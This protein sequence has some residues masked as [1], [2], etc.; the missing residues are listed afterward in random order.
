MSSQYTDV[1][2]EALSAR[3]LPPAGADA[4]R[5]VDFDITNWFLR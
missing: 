3:L 5:G 1:S 2:H 4:M